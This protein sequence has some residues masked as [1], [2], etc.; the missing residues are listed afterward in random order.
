MPE[1]APILAGCGIAVATPALVASEDE[2]R[3]AAARVGFPLALKIVSPDISHKT[4]VGGV[5]LGLASSE[6]VVEA[7]RAM[8]ERAR[9][10]RPDARIEGFSLQPMVA[11]GKELL[12]GSVRDPQ[13]GPLVVTGFGGI[14]V[15]VLRD[16]ATR[17]APVD[18]EEAR[19]MLDEL[20]LAPLLHGARGETP[21]DLVALAATIARF[22]SLCAGEEA[23]AEIEI[24]PLVASP[25]GAIAVDARAVLTPP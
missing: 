18:E 5:A 10:L 3:A 13:F 16:T 19:A 15:E 21:V 24:N 7:A 14:Y 23:L 22:S 2:A 9:G 6:A 25:A 1:L 4:D 12:V 8:R 11:P 20:R 17:L